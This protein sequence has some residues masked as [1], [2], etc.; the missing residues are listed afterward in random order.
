MRGF[1][2][3]SVGKKA[4]MAA[5]GLVLSGFV[6]AHMIG[7]LQVFLGPDALND[8]AHHL[9]S[10]PALLW[11]ARAVLLGAVL[12]HAAV[13]IRLAVENRA[14]RPVGYAA[15]ST[16]RAT[17]ASRTM[18]VSGLALAAFI[19]YHLLHFTL[20][21]TD[22]E[23]F[24]LVD[25]EGRHD[26]YAMVVLGFRRWPVSVSYVVAMAL[27]CAHLSHGVQSLFQT[28]GWN[29]ERRARALR[30]FSGAYGAILFVGNSSIPVAALAGWLKLPGGS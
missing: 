20:G 25:A 3:S 22:P 4:L 15:Q 26:V 13:G 7:N 5:S 29:D 9:Q 12:T 28:L 11:A 2:G 17:T 27:L 16:I 18:V 10:M 30:C 21:V 14:A 6:L 19:V 24:R 23:H 1:L 8:Y